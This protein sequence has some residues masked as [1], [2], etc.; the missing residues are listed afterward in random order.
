MRLLPLAVVVL[1][2]CNIDSGINRKDDNEGTFD[3]ADTVT[4]PIDTDDTDVPPP[5]E[6]NG[7]D[8]DGDGLVDEDFPDDDANGRVD[9]LDTTCPAL[10]IGDPG[11]VSINEEC[12]GTTGGGGVEVTD[13]WRVRTKWT[14]RGHQ[15]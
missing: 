12:Q 1:A 15:N 2:A 13:P 7:Y 6:C 9:C 8:D 4:P 5:E 14:Y 11:L 3:T 10:D